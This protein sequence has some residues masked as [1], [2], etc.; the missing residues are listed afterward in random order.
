MKAVI[1]AG[2]KGTRLSSLTLDLI[3]KPMIKILDKPVLLR[4]I[5][6]LRQNGIFQIIIIVGHLK[7]KIIDYFGDGSKLGVQIEYITESLPLGS[8]GSLFYLKGLMSED[9]LLLFGDTVFDI[10][11]DRMHAFH[12]KHNSVL[13]MYTHPNS[14]PYDSD[15]LV[16]DRDFRVVEL[17][18][19]GDY[20]PRLYQNSVNASFFIISPSALNYLAAPIKT[21][22][23]KDFANYHINAGHNVYAYF[24]SEYIKD[25]GTT[26]RIA[27]AA[28]DI[29]NGIVAGRNLK[30]PQKCVFIDRDG[31][32]NKYKGFI[33]D[34]SQIELLPGVADA[35]KAINKSGYLAVVVTN[36]PVIAR[37][38]CSEETLKDIHNKI[39]VELAAEGAYLD[40]IIFC[41]HHPDKGFAGEVASLKIDCNCR[42]PKTGMIDEAKSR[43][44]I[45]AASSYMVGDSPADVLTGINSGLKTIK[46]ESAEDGTAARGAVKPEDAS[47][48]A[49]AREAA[50]RKGKIVMPETAAVPDYFAKDLAAAVGIILNKNL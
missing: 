11:I 24:C 29:K 10:D 7:E 39:E 17:L 25:V 27:A 40:D 14:H 35:I 41:P 3:P 33:I 38:E 1:M 31:T 16:F 45:T 9:F 47:E 6:R 34:P 5:E 8:A 50:A 4:Q 19:K 43:F 26:D 12:K 48:K 2:G 13:T 21:D 23:E 37:G 18:K 22:M 32:I 30:N 44:N 49:A 28:A 15:L 46:I 42:K 20:R 36:Q